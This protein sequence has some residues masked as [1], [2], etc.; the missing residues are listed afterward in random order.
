MTQKDFEH[1]YSKKFR[2]SP[3]IPSSYWPDNSLIGTRI[4][5]SAEDYQE[6]GEW[7]SNVANIFQEKISDK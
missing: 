2:E 5:E 6:K 4:E 1:A 7:L 3:D